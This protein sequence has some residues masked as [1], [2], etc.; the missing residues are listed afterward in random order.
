MVVV[1]PTVVFD[2]DVPEAV[3]LARFA[4]ARISF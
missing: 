4:R 1:P 3:W 2:A